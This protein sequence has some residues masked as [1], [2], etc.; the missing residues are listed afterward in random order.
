MIQQNDSQHQQICGDGATKVIPRHIGMLMDGNG[1]WAQQRGLPRPFGHRAALQ[2]I[3]SILDACAGYDVQA[4]TLY[5]FSTENWARPQT[6]ADAFLALVEHKIAWFAENVRARGYRLRHI[7]SQVRL[8]QQLRAKIQQGIALSQN[9]DGMVVN[10][11]FNY[12]GPDEIVRATRRI[13]QAGIA[14]K[15]LNE[16]VVE[17]FLDTAGFPEME[18]VIRTGGE[19][20]LSNFCLW[21]SA[22][23]VLYSTPV[24]W[25]DFAIKDLLNAFEAFA[26]VLDS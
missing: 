16:D 4:V 7:G 2:N 10:V 13:V 3:F 9:N 26:T 11:A 15:E 18:L 1:R 17:S 8:S 22:N 20:R 5:G 25:P 12:G 14:P 23:A 21:Q 24:L 6:E 19:Q